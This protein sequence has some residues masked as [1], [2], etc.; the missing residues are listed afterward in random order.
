MIS[1]CDRYVPQDRYSLERR[2]QDVEIL[3]GESCRVLDRGLESDKDSV[4]D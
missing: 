1:P 2:P 4:H 3:P